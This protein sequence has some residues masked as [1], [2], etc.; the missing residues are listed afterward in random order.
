MIVLGASSAYAACTV[1]GRGVPFQGVR[2]EQV[3]SHLHAEKRLAA[4][5][6]VPAS[7]RPNQE[8]D[9]GGAHRR[10]TNARIELGP[11]PGLKLGLGL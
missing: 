2:L 11:G 1:D 9:S 7:C 6:C 8:D 3:Q 4:P 10:S 5:A